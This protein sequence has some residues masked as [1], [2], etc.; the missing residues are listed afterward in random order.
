MITLALDFPNE[1]LMPDSFGDFFEL[2]NN[3]EFTHWFKVVWSK[4]VP[5]STYR[6]NVKGSDLIYSY[7]D[8]SKVYSKLNEWNIKE[9]FYVLKN[10]DNFN[11]YIDSNINTGHINIV[12]EVKMT[13]WR[14]QN[15]LNNIFWE[16]ID[17]IYIEEVINNYLEEV[18][19]YKDRIV[20][21]LKIKSKWDYIIV[22]FEKYFEKKWWNP[23]DIDYYR[24]WWAMK[25]CIEKIKKWDL[26]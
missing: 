3:Y 13:S 2:L 14:I 17:D 6:N 9:T 5:L 11:F 10:E 25:T 8:L 26:I 24:Y 21:I 18:L 20:D 1:Q 4:I 15:I 19:W 23:D 12:W 16:K 22:E 7:D